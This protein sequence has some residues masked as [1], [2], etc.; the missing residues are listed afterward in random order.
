MDLPRNKPVAAEPFESRE[1][2]ILRTAICA[3]LPSLPT[4]KSGI[5]L[6]LASEQ[7]QDTVFEF[8]AFYGFMV[9]L[10]CNVN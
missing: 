3:G 5:K 6:P 2:K 7:S 8:S 10:Q 1:V 9:S 4:R